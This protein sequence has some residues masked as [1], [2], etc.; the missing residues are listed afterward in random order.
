[1]AAETESLCPK[2]RSF[3][4]FTLATFLGISG[5]RQQVTVNRSFLKLCY[6]QGN[7]SLPTFWGRMPEL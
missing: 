4:L 2:R 3:R 5:N 1:M 7:N 6:W